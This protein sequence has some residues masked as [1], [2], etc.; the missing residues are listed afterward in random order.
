MIIK[1]N[2]LKQKELAL[3]LG[4]TESYISALLSGRNY[5]LSATLANLVE[6]KLGYNSQWLLHGEG[7]KLKQVG[8]DLTL[9]S[10]RQ[11]AFLRIEK[12][13]EKELRAVLAFMD[14]LKKVEA[15]FSKMEPLE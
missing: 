3:L 5:K 11:R 9:T 2:G 8:T 13:P 7:V 1:E 6:E 12:M 4:V 15:I 10:E 14:S